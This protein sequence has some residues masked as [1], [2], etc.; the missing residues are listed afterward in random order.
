M[1]KQKL[2]Q[3]ISLLKEKYTPQDL[4]HRSEEVFSV[5]E[6]T[7]IFQNAKNIFIYNNLPDEVSTKTFI[8]KWKVDKN[9]YLPVVNGNN[10]IFRPYTNDSTQYKNRG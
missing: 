6:I 2:R 9:F 4:Q 3:N 5:L 10:L 1:D 8:E 7:G